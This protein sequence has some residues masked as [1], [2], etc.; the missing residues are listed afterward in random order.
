MIS[1]SKSILDMQITPREYLE[2]ALSHL[3]GSGPS[4]D[5]KNQVSTGST[6]GSHT[7]SASQVYLPYTAQATRLPPVINCI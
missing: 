1:G 3:N 4:V 5:A 2:T 6:H 7:Y